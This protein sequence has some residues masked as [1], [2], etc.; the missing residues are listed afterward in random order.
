MI[1]VIAAVVA[2]V[3]LTIAS[4]E[5]VSYMEGV[6][7]TRINK[8][9]RTVQQPGKI[10]VREYFWHG[11]PHCFS[12]EPYVQRWLATKPK[13]VNFQMQPAI[14][15]E[16]WKPAAQAF[17]TAAQLGLLDKIHPRLFEAIHLEKRSGLVKNEFALKLFF[18]EQGVNPEQFDKTWNSFGVSSKV[19]QAIRMTRQAGLNGVP[20]MV[21]NGKYLT[22][23]GTAGGR[24]EMFRVIEFLVAKEMAAAQ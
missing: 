9:L 23:P 8:P 4:A 10:E 18:E 5:S 13:N 16:S 6:E 20:A 12:L 14:L 21:V 15:G 17:Y 2:L 3:N 24:E 11:C 19:N 1:G 7:Y 22:D